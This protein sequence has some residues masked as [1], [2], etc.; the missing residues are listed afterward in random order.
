[1]LLCKHEQGAL[2]SLEGGREGHCCLRTP[3]SAGLCLCFSRTHAPQQKSSCPRVTTRPSLSHA[4]PACMLRLPACLQGQPISLWDAGDG[5]LRA[6][7]RGYS[8]VDEVTAAYSLAFSPDGAKLAAGYNKSLRVFDVARPGRDCAT[9]PTHRKRQEGSI[10]GRSV[11]C[12]VQWGLPSSLHACTE[13]Q[14][15]CVNGCVQQHAAHSADLGAPLTISLLLSLQA[16]SAAWHSTQP[17]QSCLLQAAT[18]AQ[19]ACLTSAPTSTCCCCRGTPAASRR[20]HFRQTATSCTRVHVAMA[21]C[22][23]GTSEQRGRCSTAW[24]GPQKAPTSGL[25]SA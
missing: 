24:L 23:V 15:R 3:S 25:P 10:A 19:S 1:M 2:C 16:S 20:W 14:Q 22:T 13:L 4:Q 17:S 5:S 9:V 12:S 7:Y 21:P 8:D 11:A 6:S 18:A